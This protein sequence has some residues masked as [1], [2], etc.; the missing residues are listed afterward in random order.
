MIIIIVNVNYSLNSFVNKGFI[1]NLFNN[2]Y[3]KIFLKKIEL[4]NINLKLKI[5]KSSIMNRNSF[6]Q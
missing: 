2:L 4:N 1:F 3:F 5:I 6:Y